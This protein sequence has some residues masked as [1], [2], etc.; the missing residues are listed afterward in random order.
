MRLLPFLV[1]L[2]TATAAAAQDPGINLHQAA[3]DAMPMED[4]LPLIEAAYGPLREQHPH[5]SFVSDAV[6]VLATDQGPP[7][8][9]F[10]FCDGKFASFSAVMSPSAAAEILAPLTRSGEP[11]PDIYPND[12]GVSL[13]FRQADLLA[14]YSGVGTKQ[15]YVSINYPHELLLTMDFAGHCEELTGE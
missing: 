4:A 11:A 1:F 8:S 7:L 5:P 3:L 12:S 9:V 13:T 14:V 2:A 6:T 15:S 10:M